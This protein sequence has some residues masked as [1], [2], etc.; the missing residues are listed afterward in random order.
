MLPSH[1][2]ESEEMS[3]ETAEMADGMS[4]PLMERQRGWGAQEE[5]PVI[6]PSFPQSDPSLF[7][8]ESQQPRHGPRPACSDNADHAPH[9][10]QWVPPPD[11]GDSIRQEDDDGNDRPSRQPATSP[12]QPMM[13]LR[14]WQDWV[15]ESFSR[16]VSQQCQVLSGLRDVDTRVTVVR[17]E[18][19]ENTSQVAAQIANASQRA[20]DE[21]DGKVESKV[22][23]LLHENEQLRSVVQQLAQSVHELKA[24]G[25][26]ANTQANQAVTDVVQ[27]M[28]AEI[29]SLKRSH[30]L[31]ME[32]RKTETEGLSAMVLSV[33][34]HMLQLKPS[35]KAAAS[36]PMPALQDFDG[37]I[38]QLERA[39]GR[40]MPNWML[41]QGNSVR[42]S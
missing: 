35:S 23:A 25:T 33:Q 10:E 3:E 2:P 30:A 1:F 19:H 7:D 4:P 14:E 37:R 12:T 32:A 22:Q 24:Q 29:E 13:S 6:V 15:Q 16:L 40:P 26:K 28:S 39:N 38:K 27:Q 8:P 21:L 34:E 20:I 31:E 5:T 41:S 9:P 42:S 11:G 18:C 17:G 36:S